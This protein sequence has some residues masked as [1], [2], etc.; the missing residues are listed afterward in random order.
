M[1]EEKTNN[2][3]GLLL[4]LLLLLGSV[5]FNVYQWR[6]HTTTV[7]QYNSEVDSL[8]NVRIE[9]ERELVSTTLEL[10]KYRGIAGNLDSLLTDAND[11]ISVQEKKIRSLLAKEKDVNKLNKS[12]KEEIA[13]L[14]EL[15]DTYLE[16][17]DALMTENAAL[18]TLNADLNNTVTNL[19][20]QKK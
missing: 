2:K 18:K 12:L 13:Q 5:G 15:K 20:E 1:D 7:I 9:V 17:I 19:N 10:D 3:G 11:K 6:N 14:K 8:I 4:L 16:K